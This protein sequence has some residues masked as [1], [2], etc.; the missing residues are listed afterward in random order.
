M[1]KDILGT[2]MLS[3]DFLKV[4][5]MDSSHKKPKHVRLRVEN[6]VKKKRKKLR[7]MK[8][9]DYLQTDYWVEM[10][11]I[12]KER[13]HESC[14]LCGAT[15]ELRTHHRSYKNKGNP[16]KELFDLVLLCSECHFL[17]HEYQRINADN[18][19]LCQRQV[20]KYRH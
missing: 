2:G 8:Y 4:V 19:S 9:S 18:P 16:E 10:R 13:Y 7:R 14:V 1:R 6:S 15:K 3:R 20:L 11:K 17:F 5:N 12:I